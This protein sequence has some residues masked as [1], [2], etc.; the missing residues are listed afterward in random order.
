MTLHESKNAG[1]PDLGRLQRVAGDP[2]P[3]RQVLHTQTDL[4]SRPAGDDRFERLARLAERENWAGDLAVLRAYVE[5]TFERLHRERRVQ[6]SPDGGHHVFN[7]GLATPR[8]EAIYGLFVPNQDPDGPPWQLDGWL[9]ESDPRLH[10]AFPELPG[11]ATYTDD[12][13]DF[14]YDRRCELSAEPRRLLETKDN[15]AVLPGPLRSNPY[16]AGLVLEGAVHRAV[17][18]VR[19]SHRIAVPCW[20]AERE[21][22]HLLLPLALTAPDGVDVALVVARDGAAYLGHTI[23]G[24]EV[25]YARA[26]QISRPGEW[27]A[28]H[29]Q[30]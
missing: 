9:P 30:S 2:A 16:Q 13:A 1:Y 8:Q 5:W 10:D 28:A 21:Q 14:V 22:V 17:A 15:R 19:R 20:D 4:G 27:L 29:A 12:P 26:R 24:L 7:T 11:P 23:L 25:A 18:R 3:G 6:T